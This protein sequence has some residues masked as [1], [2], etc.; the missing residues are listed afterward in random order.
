MWYSTYFPSVVHQVSQLSW[1]FQCCLYIEFHLWGH[2]LIRVAQKVMLSTWKSRVEAKQLWLFSWKCYLGG[3]PKAS[4]H[5]LSIALSRQTSYLKQ[6]HNWDRRQCLLLHFQLFP[7][8]PMILQESVLTF[9]KHTTVFFLQVLEINGQNIAGMSSLIAFLGS[10]QE[11]IF[12]YNFFTSTQRKSSVLSLI[13]N[14]S[15]TLTAA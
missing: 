10:G 7:T 5:D 13:L 9:P 4:K 3:D 14:V 2:L 6:A 1:Q 12:M 15:L 11:K 8:N